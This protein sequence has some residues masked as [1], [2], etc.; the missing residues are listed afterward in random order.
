MSKEYRE[1][2]KDPRWQ[3]LKSIVMMRDNFTCRC[4]GSTDKT[5]QVHHKKYSGAP[6]DAKLDDLFTM[7]YDCHNTLHIIKRIIKQTYGPENVELEYG[8]SDTT[9]SFFIK[10]AD[11]TNDTY[12]WYEVNYKTIERSLCKYGIKFVY[13]FETSNEER[14][15]TAPI[16]TMFIGKDISRQSVCDSL[17]S[18]YGYIEENVIIHEGSYDCRPFES[19]LYHSLTRKASEHFFIT[20][21]KI[22]RKGLKGIRFQPGEIETI[23]EEYPGG[24]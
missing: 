15:D 13:V 5:L 14:W 18:S 22:E 21:E 11:N 7:C 16:I 23:L 17:I 4:C 2:L 20:E 8:Y 10:S 9:H 3:K 1:L 6:W 19:Q 12:G 24:F